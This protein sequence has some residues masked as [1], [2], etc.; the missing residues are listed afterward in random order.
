MQKRSG[1][2][3]LISVIVATF[4]TGIVALSA[5]RVFGLGFKGFGSHLED[6]I[7]QNYALSLVSQLRNVD[8]NSISA[9]TRQS[10]D[11]ATELSESISYEDREGI[12]HIKI[13]I[14]KGDE[15]VPRAEVTLRRSLKNQSP[16]AKVIH[17][18]A[19]RDALAALSQKAMT[20]TYLLQEDAVERI[21]GVAVGSEKQGI[22]MGKS[23]AAT[24]NVFR[25]EQ[26]NGSDNLLFINEETDPETGS[27]LCHFDAFDKASIQPDI[28]V[29]DLDNAETGYVEIGKKLIFAWKNLELT[30][31]LQY[32]SVSKPYPFKT[33][34]SGLFDRNT[35]YSPS[36]MTGVWANSRTTDTADVYY[37]DSSRTGEDVNLFWLGYTGDEALPD[38][39]VPMR[40]LSVGNSLHQQIVVRVE[41]IYGTFY[42]L[43]NGQS[44]NFPEG[45][46]FSVTINPDSHYVA[47]TP[48]IAS[49]LIYTDTHI[50]AS[51]ALLAKHS[52]TVPSKSNQ[53]IT[54]TAI[55]AQTGETIVI[56]NGMTKAVSY[57][58]SW[59]TSIVPD[60]GYIA[61]KAS[62]AS[63]IVTGDFVLSV[64]DAASMNDWACVIPVPGAGVYWSWTAPE[65]VTQILCVSDGWLGNSTGS[66]W[67]TKNGSWYGRST[68]YY[69]NSDERKYGWGPNSITC[70]NCVETGQCWVQCGITLIS[71][72]PGKT[73]TFYIANS[74]WKGRNYAMRFIWGTDVNAGKIG[75]SAFS[76]HR[77]LDQR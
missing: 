17:Q 47:G 32:K 66:V 43:T 58:S 4:I 49:G 73:Y 72:T 37:M 42:T 19:G 29:S 35:A 75:S 21:N 1:S 36:V 46:S 24:D 16:D 55:D 53:T 10:I 67:F 44:G 8:A 20:E 68:N 57:G 33:L 7:A 13:E 61:G 59:T 74:Y 41:D 34:Y 65:H 76:Y 14:F 30:G 70:M 3:L 23:V 12:R 40:T 64:S 5:A 25:L 18:E 22:Y 48:N 26:N 56:T 9:V 71:V 27:V 45:S 62:P 31:P 6:N 63:G 39:P 50:T 11:A 60:S 2:A 28:L 15:T 52:V 51:N 77:Y 38:I 69:G 54:L